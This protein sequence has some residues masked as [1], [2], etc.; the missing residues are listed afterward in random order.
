MTLKIYLAA[1]IGVVVS[2]IVCFIILKFIFNESINECI[3]AS[4]A[5]AIGCGISAVIMAR[6]SMKK[7]A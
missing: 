7:K 5:G 4:G 3:G 2:F 1:L 6:R